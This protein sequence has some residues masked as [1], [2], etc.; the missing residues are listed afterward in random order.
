MPTFYQLGFLDPAFKPVLF[1]KVR[2]TA[3][4]PRCGA[5]MTLGDKDGGGAVVECSRCSLREIVP[6][7]DADTIA[8]GVLA[9]VRR[10]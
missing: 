9:W 4:C 7:S 1:W 2:I 8:A 10:R 6:D 3:S 5:D